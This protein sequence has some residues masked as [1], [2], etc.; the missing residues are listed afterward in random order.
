MGAAMIGRYRPQQDEFTHEAINII[1]R[2]RRRTFWLRY[3]P[4]ADE[5]RDGG[6]GC[7]AKGCAEGH[8]A[9]EGACARDPRRAPTAR[10]DHGE[11]Y[12]LDSPAA[13]KAEQG[14]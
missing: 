10:R 3:L 12:G 11:N 8:I 14:R 6:Q 2:H 7:D 1:Y 4:S 5:S 9:N 13:R